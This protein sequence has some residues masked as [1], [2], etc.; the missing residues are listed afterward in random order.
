M[1]IATPAGAKRWRKEIAESLKDCPPQERWWRGADV[2]SSS[3]AMFHALCDEGSRWKEPSMLAGRGTTP[4][5]AADF[6]RCQRLIKAI[7]EWRSRL[8]EVADC[9]PGTAWPAIIA[10][11]DELEKAAPARVR[12]ILDELKAT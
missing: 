6:G 11:W 7:P 1:C 3:A 9:Y 2:G 5:D 8:S 10:R 4:L 12:E